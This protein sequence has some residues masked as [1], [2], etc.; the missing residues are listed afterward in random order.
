MAAPKRL[1]DGDAQRGESRRAART[2]ALHLDA[3]GAVVLD[4]GELDVAS[5]GDQRGPQ[6]VEEGL[7]FGARRRCAL[8]QVDVRHA[9]RIGRAPVRI[10][11]DGGAG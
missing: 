10:E 11:A 5:V 7:H 9:G 1:L 8:H 3:H 4:A 6:V 2:L